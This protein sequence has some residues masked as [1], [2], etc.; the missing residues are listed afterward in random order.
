MLARPL[1]A[2]VVTLFWYLF[3]KKTTPVPARTLFFYFSLPWLWILSYLWIKFWADLMSCLR[4]RDPAAETYPQTWIFNLML[5]FLIIQALILSFPGLL[6]FLAGWFLLEAIL[7]LVDRSSGEAGTMLHPAQSRKIMLS[8]LGLILWFFLSAAALQAFLFTRYYPVSERRLE[9]DQLSTQR[10]PDILEARRGLALGLRDHVI[11]PLDL[12]DSER[13]LLSYIVS[14]EKAAFPVQCSVKIQKGGQRLSELHTCLFTRK[15]GYPSERKRWE[16]LAFPDI[17]TD[18]DPV[19]LHFRSDFCPGLLSRIANLDRLI[20]Y[21]LNPESA[22]KAGTYRIHWAPLPLEQSPPSSSVNVLL[23]DIDTLRADYLGCYGFPGDISPAI[24]RVAREGVLF[25]TVYSQATW[26]L[27]S[28]VSLMT[29]LYVDSHGLFNRNQQLYDWPFPTLAG[30]LRQKGFLTLGAV[31]GGYVSAEFGFATDFHRYWEKSETQSPINDAFACAAGLLEQFSR[32]SFFLFLQTFIVHDYFHFTPDYTDAAG[33]PLPDALKEKAYMTYVRDFYGGKTQT[34]LSGQDY[35]FLK[36]LYEEGV[37]ITDYY[38]GRLVSHLKRLDLY[39]R[40]WIIITSDHGE[41]F[42]EVHNEG[43]F[44]SLMHGRPPY[45][46]QTRIPLIMKFPKAWRISGNRTIT[47]KVN[48]VDILPTILDFLGDAVPDTLQGKSLKPLIDGTSSGW[49]S[50]TLTGDPVFGFAYVDEAA[51]KLIKRILKKGP[52][53]FELYHL[54]D[55]GL[56]GSTLD[57]AALKIRLQQAM[58]GLQA[59]S[60]GRYRDL[61][62]DVIQQISPGLKD[63]LKELGY[64]Q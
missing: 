56:E 64:I 39:D 28:T 32:E 61:D 4:S 42:G 34:E 7:W 48:G 44:R 12:G 13:L 51:N 31:D 17:Q 54:K 29:S 9:P 43:R 30:Y 25:E 53:S 18:G 3:L 6:L 1:G 8:G 21:A 22:R 20:Y 15:T 5:S 63:R 45:E 62:A 55:G 36:E 26:T 33:L 27:P 49:H 35:E 50:P 47:Q 37:R 38:F 52:P 10:P 2:I 23:F 59:E 58:E 11:L 57:E 19:T 41:G 24:D 14:G 40:T 60:K 16:D 46:N